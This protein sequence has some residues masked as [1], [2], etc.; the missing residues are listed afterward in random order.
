MMPVAACCYCVLFVCLSPERL[1]CLGDLQNGRKEGCSGIRYIDDDD[2]DDERKTAL[3]LFNK[4]GRYI[5]QH[6]R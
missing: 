3:F 4:R 2:D 6:D 5:A 1:V